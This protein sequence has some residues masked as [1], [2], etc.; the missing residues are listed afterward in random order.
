MHSQHQTYLREYTYVPHGSEIVYMTIASEWPGSGFS[1]PGGSYI[2]G[3]RTL[4]IIGTNGCD[5]ENAWEW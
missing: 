3:D 2:G 1:G 5:V 4:V